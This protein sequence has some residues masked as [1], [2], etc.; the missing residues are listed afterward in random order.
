[1]CFDL[2]VNSILKHCSQRSFLMKKLRSK[3][4]SNKQLNAMFDTIIFS[5][6]RY[7]LPAWGGF[8]LLMFITELTQQWTLCFSLNSHN[9]E[10][11]VYHSTHTTVNI[12]SDIFNCFL[13]SGVLPVKWLLTI[14]SLVPNVGIPANLTDFRPISITPILSCVV[15]IFCNLLV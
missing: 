4:L 3:G 7:A 8:Y 2:H 15:Q 11:F 9:N 12:V 13:S 10:H 6:L 1:L 5:R 14:I